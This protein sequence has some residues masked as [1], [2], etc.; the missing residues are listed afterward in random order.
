MQNNLISRTMFKKSNPHYYFSLAMIGIGTTILPVLRAFLILKQDFVLSDYFP[1]LVFLLSVLAAGGG[2]LLGKITFTKII[3]DVYEVKDF[4]DGIT[5]TVLTLSTAHTDSPSGEY[6]KVQ[7]E[8]DKEIIEC[9]L[10]LKKP[11]ATANSV[12][13]KMQGRLFME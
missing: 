10:H 6:A 13:T 7:V 5:V 8:K 1:M 11:K 3:K 4:E 2:Y 9:V 12:Y